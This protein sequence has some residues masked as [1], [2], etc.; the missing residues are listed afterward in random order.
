MGVGAAMIVVAWTHLKDTHGLYYY[1]GKFRVKGPL[2][3][4]KRAHRK[5]KGPTANEKGPA[6]TKGPH[7]KQ[8]GGS[9]FGSYLMNFKASNH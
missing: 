4:A 5:R 1:S 9:A 3:F 6:Q 8:K 7:S 2:K